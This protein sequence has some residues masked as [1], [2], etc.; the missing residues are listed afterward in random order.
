MLT[1]EILIT[2]SFF[3]MRLRTIESASMFLFA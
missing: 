1:F 3:C 2:D